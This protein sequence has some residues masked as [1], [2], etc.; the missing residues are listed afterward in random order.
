M[1]NFTRN[2]YS[3]NKFLNFLEGRKNIIKIFTEPTG[4]SPGVP[5]GQYGPE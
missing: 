5:T 2:L 4:K 3:K 1:F